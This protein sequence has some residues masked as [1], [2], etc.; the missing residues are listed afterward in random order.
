[1]NQ[2]ANRNQKATKSGFPRTLIFALLG[3]TVVAGGACGGQKK[4]PGTAETQTGDKGKILYY[5]NPGA[6]NRCHARPYGY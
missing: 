1:M 3:L 6:K 4:S 5:R 2:Q